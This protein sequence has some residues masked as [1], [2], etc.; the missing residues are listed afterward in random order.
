MEFG[1]PVSWLLDWREVAVFDANAE[2]LGAKVSTLM[3]AAGKALARKAAAMV[4]K[5]EILI[6]C[7]P[8]NNGGDGFAAAIQLAEMDGQVR[9][10][11]SHDSQK[12]AAATSFR[13]SCKDAGVDVEIW[14]KKSKFGSPKLLV[15]CLLGVG[16]EDA[17]RGVIREVIE[18]VKPNNPPL[19][20]A[21]D[22]PSG[23]GSDIF[24]AADETLTF[25]A[26]KQGME[27]Q[28]VG[29]VIIAPLPFP[30]RTTDCGPGDALRYPSLDPSAHKGQR[31]KLLIIGGGPYHGA[32]ILSGRAAA[33]SGCDLIHVAMPRFAVSQAT[34]PDH[35]ISKQISD[36]NILGERGTEDLLKIISEQSFDAVLIGPGLGRKQE[37]MDATRELLEKLAEL[38]IPAVIDA[39]AIY[40][41]DNGKWPKNLLGVATPH[42]RELRMWLWDT[43][44]EDALSEEG[45]SGESRV[46]VRTGPV[47]QL[48][49]LDGRYCECSGGHPRMATG[50][51]GDL[52]AGMI[53]GLLAQGMK[54]WPAARLACAVMREAGVQTA[55]EFGP[56][57]LATDVP[58]H[59][60]RVLAKWSADS[61]V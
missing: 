53:A 33:R 17:P 22:I 61:R 6:L 9:V 1:E 26:E 14:S 60:A 34:W 24:L 19:I 16:L 10:I 36:E 3:G 2:A 50:G 51:T 45:V 54:P 25:H 40:A 8:G 32:P 15:D 11:A 37:T 55:L 47:D 43:K 49:G 23:L 28:D 21:C 30:A 39:D 52:L 57:L 46:I 12:G 29:E 44:P 27:P 20:L 5:G 7:G 4:P 35:L 42:A 48:T 18:W 38:E 59:I 56:G 13:K 58:P 31:G 41:L